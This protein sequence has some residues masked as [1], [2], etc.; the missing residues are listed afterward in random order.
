MK[1]R[2]GYDII[3]ECLQPIPMILVLNVHPSRAADLLGPDVIRTEPFVPVS[4]YMDGFGNWCT[5]IVAPPPAIRIYSETVIQDTGLPDEVAPGALQVP[6]EELPE[7]VLVFLLASRYCET[8]QL[9][10]V[11][12]QLFGHTPPGWER[13]TAICEFVH[14]HIAFDYQ[15][16]RHT[17][18]ALGAYNDSVGVCRDYAHLALTFCRCMNIPARYCTGYLGD[19]G[20][21]PS[22]DP[23]DFSG[24]F[25]AYLGGRWYTFDA[26]HNKPRIG[27]VLMA[28]GRD[29]A[30]VAISTTFGPSFLKQFLVVTDEIID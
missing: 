15:N 22:P 11:A 20:V 18:T 27:R 26:R 14:N 29:A 19:I 23:M 2:I 1:I 12:W 13:V 5:R 9:T 4:V 10:D 24:W 8:E 17:R 3:F 30:D 16:A 7:E 6:V 21:P 28:R 25:E